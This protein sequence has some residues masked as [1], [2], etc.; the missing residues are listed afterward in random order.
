MKVLVVNCGSSSVKWQVVDTAAGV[1]REGKA[2]RIGADFTHAEALAPAVEAAR[3]L[4]VEGVGH[5]VVHGGARFDAPSLLTDEVVEA[6]EACV[7]LAPL[8]N[9]PNLLGIRAVKEALGDV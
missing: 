5:R 7:P 1:L 8:H 9:P 6:I 3:E 2:E 4:G